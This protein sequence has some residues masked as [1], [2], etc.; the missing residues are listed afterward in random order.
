VKRS[1]LLLA[2]IAGAVLVLD[3]ATKQWVMRSLTYQQPVEILGPYLRFTY[4][5]NS[6]VAFGLGAGTNFPYYIFSILAAVAILYLFLRSQV[7]T[8]GRQLALALILGGALGNLVDRV[9]WGEVVDF[10]EVGFK[11]WHWPVFNIADSA[12]S[13]GVVLFALS[14]P[15]RPQPAVTAGDAPDANAAPSAPPG[16][17]RDPSATHAGSVGSGAERG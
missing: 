4:T 2:I 11:G 14:R 16:G 10:I 5:R 15:R 3:L 1:L 9:R 6:G 12:V 8:R 17:L 13:V 7:P